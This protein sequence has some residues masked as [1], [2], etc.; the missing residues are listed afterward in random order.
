MNRQL[1]YKIFCGVARNVLLLLIVGQRVAC[2][3]EAA[4]ASKDWPQF[5][6][7]SGSAHGSAALTDEWDPTRH[8]RWRYELPGPGGSSPIV[9]GNQVFLTAYSGYGVDERSPGDPRNLVRHLVCVDRHDGQ[10]LWQRDIPA[11]EVVDN[12]ADFRRQ[13]G[14]ATSTPASDGQRVYASF[15]NSGVFAFDLTGKQ[16]WH[17]RVGSRVHNWG[18]AAS[19]TVDDRFVFVNAAVE[20]KA[21]LALDKQTGEEVWRFERV[22]GSWSTPT[23]VDLPDGGREVL[24]NVKQR[25]LGLD[26]ESGRQLWF[27]QTDESVAAST[28]TAVDGVVY[29]SSG[30]PRFVAALRVADRSDPNRP[31]LVWRTDGI[32]SGISSPLFYDGRIYVVDR[33]IAACLN[34]ATGQ[35][36]A[37]TRLTPSEATFY[38]SPIAAGKT[39]VAVSRDAG[40]YIFSVAPSFKM[41]ANN[42][43]DPSVF[44]GTPAV[45]DGELLLRSD[46]YLYCIGGQPRE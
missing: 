22:I 24:L 43:L 40:A 41:V 25:L 5:R 14:Y 3:A 29:L 11:E 34:A 27:Y 20:E 18:S 7:P 10:R 23:P 26:R 32:G 4:E 16:L 42:R 45:H 30:N 46:G 9:V 37:K 13:H 39:I 31:S 44:N 2:L 36:V 8:V 6:G 35:I 17:H 15:E 28:P 19:L 38:A 1:G 12:Y 21:L 33:S